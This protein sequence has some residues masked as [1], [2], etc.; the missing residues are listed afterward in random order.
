MYHIVDGF[1]DTSVISAHTYIHT[2]LLVY[3]HTLVLLPY[4]ALFCC[5]PRSIQFREVTLLFLFHG[6][7]ESEQNEADSKKQ[8]R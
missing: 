7:I 6:T 5:Q 8:R 1:L 3:I 2:V 4:R